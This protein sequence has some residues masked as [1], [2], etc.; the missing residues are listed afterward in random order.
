VDEEEITQKF[1]KAKDLVS[2]IEERYRELALTVVFR[3][4]LEQSA[5]VTK[6]AAPSAV[7]AIEPSMALNEFLASRKPTSHGDR[8][9]LVAYYYLHSKNEPV[10]R[11][12]VSEA[13]TIVRTARPRNLSDIIGKCVSKGYLTEYPAGKDDKRAWQITQTG[14]RYLQ[15]EVP[16]A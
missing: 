16:N 9:L 14:E 11:A 5:G 3:W 1:N 2:G 12:E 15:E 13:Y 8:V 10:T 4:L 6:A 7:P